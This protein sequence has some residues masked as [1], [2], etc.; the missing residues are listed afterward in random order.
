MWRFFQ[1]HEGETTA[2]LRAFTVTSFSPHDQT[3]NLR[4]NSTLFTFLRSSVQNIVPLVSI[5]TIN[6]TS[7]RLN[8]T[9]VTCSDIETSESVSTTISIINENAIGELVY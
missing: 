5:L 3:Q 8:G 6:A 9:M 7:D 1:V 4:V 2:T